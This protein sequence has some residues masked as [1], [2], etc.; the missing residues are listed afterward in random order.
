MTD[1]NLKELLNELVKSPKENEC[2]EFIACYQNCCLC[3]QLGETM[4]NQTLRE[5]FEVEEKSYSG[6][7]S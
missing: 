5:R 6:V 7:K 2:L 1:Q 3:Y 4:S